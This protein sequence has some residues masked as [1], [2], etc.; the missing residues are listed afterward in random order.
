MGLNG[1]VSGYTI[2]IGSPR[3]DGDQRTP[4]ILSFIAW[5]QS[6][7]IRIPRAWWALV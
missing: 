1:V 5:Y 4:K 6:I 3:V 2:S 7:G